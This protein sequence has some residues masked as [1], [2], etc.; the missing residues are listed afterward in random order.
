MN[1]FSVRLGIFCLPVLA[2]LLLTSGCLSTSSEVV[3][4]QATDPQLGMT[5]FAADRTRFVQEINQVNH[6]PATFLLIC[7]DLVNQPSVPDYNEFCSVL[8][9][10][11]KNVYCVPGNHDNNLKLF[12]QYIGHDHQTFTVGK[13]A[14]VLLNSTLIKECTEPA[15][16]WQMHWL[17][18]QLQQ[19]AEQ[20]TPVIIVMHH[21]LFVNSL[22]EAEDYSNL[23]IP[24]RKELFNL[25]KRSGVI[26]VLYGHTHKTG[27]FK[28]EGIIFASSP[29]TSKN[30]DQRPYG[31]FLWR[32]NGE[33]LSAT[34]ISLTPTATVK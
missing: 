18:E 32:Y 9:D 5:D 26:A 8:K 17:K 27:I 2:A 12:R 29:T 7:G 14:F 20:Q 25:F 4:A 6:S 13:L 31:Y 21:P 11:R 33:K 1:K 34:S 15:S 28:S 10:C 22:N 24:Q 23:P 3:F 30:F 16:S 19:Y